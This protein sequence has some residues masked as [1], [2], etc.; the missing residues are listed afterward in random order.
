MKRIRFV[1]LVGLALV[2]AACSNDDP[3]KIEP[4]RLGKRGESCLNSSECDK[5]LACIRNVCTQSDFNVAIGAKVCQQ[6]DCAEAADCCANVPAECE[7]YAENYARYCQPYEVATCPQQTTLASCTTD[8]QCTVDGEACDTVSGYCRCTENPDYDTQNATCRMSCQ[9]CSYTCSGERCVPKCTDDFDC[10]VGTCDTASGTCFE[11]ESNDDCYGAGEECRD[12]TCTVPCKQNENC[13][14]FHTCN[15]DTGECDYTGCKDD[16]ECQFAFSPTDPSA[17]ASRCV[18]NERTG[19]EGQPDRV[20]RVPCVSDAEC[21]GRQEVCQNGACVYMGCE[22][23]QEC[24]AE[25]G[26]AEVS[27]SATFTPKAVCREP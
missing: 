22:S 27:A 2:V 14:L 4:S 23:D 17:K 18:E 15:Q 13:P 21:T 10:G 3:T 20:C 26:L 12:H 11:C 16:H 5:S 8:D 1:T 7:N 19:A 24:R 25:L 9:A 6:I